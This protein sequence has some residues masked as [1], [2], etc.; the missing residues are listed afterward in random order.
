MIVEGYKGVCPVRYNFESPTG[1]IYPRSDIAIQH[2]CPENL[3]AKIKCEA[4]R[5]R[6]AVAAF[7]DSDRPRKLCRA[8]ARAGA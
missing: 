5:G 3:V 2:G 8:S 1:T 4:A 6:A 7:S